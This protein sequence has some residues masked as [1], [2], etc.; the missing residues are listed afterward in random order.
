MFMILGFNILNDANRHIVESH[1]PK[2]DD[3]LKSHKCTQFPWHKCLQDISDGL[4]AFYLS[5]LLIVEPATDVA[6]YEPIELN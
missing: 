3:M 1:L 4:I 2:T 5:N 6:D